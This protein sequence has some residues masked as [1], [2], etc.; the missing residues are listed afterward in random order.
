MEAERLAVAREH[1]LAYQEDLRGRV[2][3]AGCDVPMSAH[4]EEGS[5]VE[6]LDGHVR[7]TRADLLVMTTHGRGPLSRAWLG[8]VADGLIRRTPC[9]ILAIRP[10]EGE[11]LELKE[12]EFRHL[13]VT[14][15]GSPESREILPYAQDLA[16]ISGARMTLLR[17]VSPHFPLTST[18]ISHTSYGSLG[19]EEETEAALAALEEEALELRTKGFTVDVKTVTASHPPEGI[20]TFATE[21]GVDLIAMATHGR[22][23]VSRFFLGSVSDKVIRAGAFPVLLH[24]AA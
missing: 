1:A 6:R 14:L 16:R 20:L 18:F 11:K 8:S 3:L 12:K 4:V 10:D 24:R 17:V 13:L 9:P 5:V 2:S 23:G 15:D 22:G 7:E 21:E 19:P